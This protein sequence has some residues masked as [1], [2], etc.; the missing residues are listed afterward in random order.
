[1]LEDTAAGGKR[2]L[3]L[4]LTSPRGGDSATVIIPEAARLEEMKVAGTPV[5]LRGGKFRPFFGWHFQNIDGLPPEGVEIEVVLG[6]TGPMDW[7]LFDGTRGLPPS[8]DALRKARPATAVAIQ[9]G[10]KTMVSR[11]VRI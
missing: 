3:R 7:Y 9:E 10:D 4:R 8:G 11:K 5:V 1:V 2:H 6:G